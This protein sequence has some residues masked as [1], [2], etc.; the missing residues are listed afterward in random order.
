MPKY[1]IYHPVTEEVI[2][3][4]GK[5]DMTPKKQSLIDD[6][7]EIKRVTNKVEGD[8]AFLRYED[9]K[10]VKKNEEE[11]GKIEEERNKSAKEQEAANI[12]SS[13][14]SSKEELIKLKA[15]LEAL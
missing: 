14:M 12:L 5:P 13:L 15:E 1:I 9:G 4:G 6:G 7:W 11:I 8:L 10:L 2:Y 3:Y